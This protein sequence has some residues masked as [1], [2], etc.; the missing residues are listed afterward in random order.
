[1]TVLPKPEA[2]GDTATGGKS[3]SNKHSY[4]H[5]RRSSHCDRGTVQAGKRSPFLSQN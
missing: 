1:M 3:E 5:H 4:L 2:M